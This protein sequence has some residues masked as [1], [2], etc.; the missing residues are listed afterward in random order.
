MSSAPL[1]IPVIRLATTNM[2][3]DK[4]EDYLKQVHAENYHGLD[5]DMPDA[6]DEWLTEL[7]ADDFIQYADQAI[8]LVKAGRR[9]DGIPF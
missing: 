4:F 6:F 8:A 9:L 7:S 2:N 5:D 1:I 3:K